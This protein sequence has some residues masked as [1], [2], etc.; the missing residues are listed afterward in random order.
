MTP[1]DGLDALADAAQGAKAAA[2]ALRWLAACAVAFAGLLVL[3]LGLAMFERNGAAEP[4]QVPGSADLDFDLSV[5]RTLS[6]RNFGGDDA[7]P[8]SLWSQRPD[9]RFPEARAAE[10]RLVSPLD[11]WAAAISGKSRFRTA[12]RGALDALPLLLAGIVLALLAAAVAGAIAELASSPARDEL[13][14]AARR[15][16][17]IAAGYALVIHPLW[18]LLDPAV[19][20]ERT[21]SLGVGFSAALFVGAFAGTLPGAAAR[22]LFAREG[23]AR[24]LSALQGR[25]ALLAA[26]RL[27]AVDAT[28]WLL[29]LLPALAAAAVF[30]QAKADQDPTIEASSSGLG[31]LIRAAMREP[32]VAE[33][34]SSCA[35][36]A[37]GLVVLWYVGHRFVI[38]LRL[39]LGS[40][41]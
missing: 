10:V 9:W 18:P 33:R 30:A 6:Q 34:L 29:P 25:P 14:A 19:F 16:A 28:D 39:A 15:A 31:A 35:L 41:A 8:V 21:R 32:S 24:S 5:L 12:A 1:T 26:A 2:A 38:E 20:Y 40:H 37:G 36:V 4:V 22:A 27:A 11:A 13:R 3:A 17:L 23:P 7:V